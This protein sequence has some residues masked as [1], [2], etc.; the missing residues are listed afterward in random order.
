MK[1][2]ITICIVGAFATSCKKDYSCVCTTVD[3]SNG[4]TETTVDT[5]KAKSKKTDAQAWCDAIPK[6]KID[7]G[8]SSS[9]P[10]NMTCEL[11]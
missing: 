2:F 8:S 6:S 1:H 4:K 10:T 5:Y 7:V 9:T 3:T 11:K